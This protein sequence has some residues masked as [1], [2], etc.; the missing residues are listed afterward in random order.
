MSEFIETI[1][2]FYYANTEISI[3]IAVAILIAIFI[4]PKLAGKILG[5]IAIIAIVGYLV[6]A[7]MGIVDKGAEKKDAASHRTDKSY[8]EDNN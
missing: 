2:S 4:N 3:A 6:V 1:Q 8:S 5:A 7:V